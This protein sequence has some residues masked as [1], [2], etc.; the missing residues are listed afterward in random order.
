[1]EEEITENQGGNTDG[2]SKSLA[3]LLPYQWKKGQSG[4]IAGRPKGKTMKE[5][6]RELLMCQSEEERQEFLQGIP[7]KDIW[8]MAEGLPQQDITSGGEALIPVPLI[9]YVRDNNSNKQNREDVQED[10]DSTRGDIGKQNSLNTDLPN[11]TSPTGQTSNVDEH[12]IGVF[13][14]S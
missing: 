11:L 3:N 14:P 8:T 7:K 10:K 2:K 12:S 6:A 9:N 1:M 13:S 4:N 5:Y